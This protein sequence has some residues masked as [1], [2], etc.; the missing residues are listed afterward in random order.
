MTGLAVISVAVL[1]AVPVSQAVTAEVRVVSAFAHYDVSGEF[2]DP[3]SG[4]ASRGAGTGTVEVGSAYGAPTGL[5]REAAMLDT[6]TDDDTVQLTA[7][8]QQLESQGAFPSWM[9]ASP[10][11]RLGFWL[12]LSSASSAGSS[13]FLEGW[14]GMKGSGAGF[15]YAIARYDPI[16]N[17]YDQRDTWMS[18]EPTDPAAVW[19][20]RK[21][22][23]DDPPQQ[24]TWEQ[25]IEHTRGTYN[26]QDMWGG[27]EYGLSFHQGAAGLFS[28]I[29]GVT[30]STAQWSSVTD[31]ELRPASGPPLLDDCKNNGWRH[32]YPANTFKNQGDCIAAIVANN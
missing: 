32:N 24:M 27:F 10:D 30:A 3:N 14:I 16:A 6:P 8:T 17:G 12:Y 18:I 5:G 19:S 25:V 7:L 29:D 22:W 31:F 4:W 1:A 2:I 20:V 28:A 21:A 15:G 13:P 26:G 11:L 9:A 23:S